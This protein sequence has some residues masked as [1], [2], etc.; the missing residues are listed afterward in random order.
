MIAPEDSLPKMVFDRAR[1]RID[2]SV[3]FDVSN[4]RSNIL[5]CID[6]L[7]LDGAVA[8]SGTRIV[9]RPVPAARQLTD[10]TAFEECL[11]LAP[12]AGLQSGRRQGGVPPRRRWI[13]QVERQQCEVIE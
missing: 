3:Y 9:V 5:G 1:A 4:V 8:S 11:K 2:S 10:L 12:T 7:M 13:K 6:N